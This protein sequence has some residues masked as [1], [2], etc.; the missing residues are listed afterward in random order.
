MQS[1]FQTACCSSMNNKVN[2]ESSGVTSAVSI[3]NITPSAYWESVI[4][5]RYPFGHQMSGV[6]CC[7]GWLKK[8]HSKMNSLGLCGDR[9]GQSLMN[10]TSNSH[11][12][13]YYWLSHTVAFLHK[14]VPH[15]KVIDN[16]LVFSKWKHRIPTTLVLTVY[17]LQ[18]PIIQE[19][20]VCQKCLVTKAIQRL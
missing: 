6:L 8:G 4:I 17:H 2:P 14:Q 9:E 7:V 12:K 20:Q 1:L 18:C 13:A 3:C 19:P 5:L 11:S 15:T 10:W 16:L